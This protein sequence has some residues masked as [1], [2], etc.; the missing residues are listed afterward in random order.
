MMANFEAN[1]SLKFFLV[2]TQRAEQLPSPASAWFGSEDLQFFRKWNKSS[3][4]CPFWRPVNE[5][6]GNVVRV[7]QFTTV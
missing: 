3:G 2:F 1:S 6:E 4:P 5:D 7:S